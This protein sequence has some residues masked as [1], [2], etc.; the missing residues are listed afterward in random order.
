MSEEGGGGAE[1]AWGASW[2]KRADGAWDGIRASH[3]L[4]IKEGIIDANEVDLRVGSGDASDEATDA[5]KAIDTNVDLLR[6]LNCLC[7]RSEV[8]PIRRLRREVSRTKF[9]ARGVS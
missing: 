1:R 8:T 3:V 5:A 6:H 4:S 2:G 9:G 7:G